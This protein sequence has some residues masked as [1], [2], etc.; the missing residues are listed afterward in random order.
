MFAK[1]Y[2]Q[3]RGILHSQL[4]QR[5]AHS[6]FVEKGV[7]ELI[8]M[9]RFFFKTRRQELNSV[10]GG[11]YIPTPGPAIVEG[12]TYVTVAKP[13]QELGQTSTTLTSLPNFIS[14]TA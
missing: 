3:I 6:K 8:L 10:E 11:K 12:R 2:R 13:L 4:I 7:K 1:S 9:Q 14:N 5:Y